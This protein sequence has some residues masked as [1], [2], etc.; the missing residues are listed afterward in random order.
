MSGPGSLA[1]LLCQSIA[2]SRS[3]THTEVLL[4]D[5]VEPD[6]HIH[7]SLLNNR[8]IRLNSKGRGESMGVARI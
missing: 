3:T 8:S 4:S 2:P 7:L 6:E 5:T 1:A